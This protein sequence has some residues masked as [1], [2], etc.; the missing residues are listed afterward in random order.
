ME[1]RRFFILA[2]ILILA[3]ILWVTHIESRN[4]NV[5]DEFCK[6]NDYATVVMRRFGCYCVGNNRPARQIH[7]GS[8]GD[9]YFD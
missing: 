7:V 5:M 8:T 6:K 4:L 9:L 2:A 3:L 1:N